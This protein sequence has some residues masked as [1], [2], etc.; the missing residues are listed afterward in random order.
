MSCWRLRIIP[1]SSCFLLDSVSNKAL[2]T[3]LV[4]VSEPGVGIDVVSE[5]TLSVMASDAAVDA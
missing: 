1:F 3:F 4:V 5:E 2:L